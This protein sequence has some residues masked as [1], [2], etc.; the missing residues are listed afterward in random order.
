VAHAVR[1]RFPDGQIFVDLGGS[2]D[3]PADPRDVL[4]IFLRAAG[5]AG[6]LPGSL[7]E[8]AALWQ[9]IQAGRLLLLVLD[10]ARDEAQ[11]RALLP[12]AGCGPSTGGRSARPRSRSTPSCPGQR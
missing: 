10:D 6:P 12:V 11:L 1:S 3:R 8:R 7:A 4:G 9:T 5:P 2:G